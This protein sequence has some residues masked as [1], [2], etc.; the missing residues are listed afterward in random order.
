ML[1]TTILVLL[2]IFIYVGGCGPSSSDLFNN[3]PIHRLVKGLISYS[4]N[5]TMEINKPFIV[6]ASITKSIKNDVLFK[7]LDTIVI[8]SVS[9]IYLSSRVKMKLLNIREND[10]VIKPLNTEEQAIDDSTNTIWR[11]GVSP[12][13]GGN[14]TILLVAN[15][16]YFGGKEE[17][18]KDIFVESKEIFVLS[19]WYQGWGIYLSEFGPVLSVILAFCCGLGWFYDRFI[20]KWI[21]KKSH[22]IG[23]KK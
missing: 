1:C 8:P 6:S 18:S 17:S 2:I 4:I 7:G 23:F 12:L 9:S 21:R 3:D 10:F 20:S 11:W 19:K 5:D 14:H 15:V 13:K 16:K 22:P